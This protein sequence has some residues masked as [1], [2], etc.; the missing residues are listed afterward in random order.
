VIV[1]RPFMHQVC[2]IVETCSILG[3]RI[4]QWMAGTIEWICAKCRRK[5]CLVSGD[6][7]CQSQR[8]G[9]PRTKN[10]PC[11]HNT[12]AVW[13]EWNTLVADNL[14]QAADMTI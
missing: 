10:V 2:E 11:T 12:P 3:T 8:S 9:S 14:A 6:F 1:W 13:M 7:E 4:R 5:M